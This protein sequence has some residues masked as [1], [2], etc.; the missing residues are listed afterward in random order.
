MLQIKPKAE[1]FRLGVLHPAPF[2]CGE[3][4]HGCAIA[5]SVDPELLYALNLLC[6]LTTAALAAAKRRALRSI[7]S[8]VC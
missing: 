6:V 4:L 5:S 3:E 2:P 7:N 8:S 1:L